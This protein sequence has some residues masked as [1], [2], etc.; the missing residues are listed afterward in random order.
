MKKVIMGMFVTVL[1]ITFLSAPA[2]AKLGLDSAE[3]GRV[4]IELI[5]WWPQVGGS[6][7]FVEDPEAIPTDAITDLDID[8]VLNLKLQDATLEVGVWLNLTKRNRFSLYWLMDQRSGTGLLDQTA[9]ISDSTFIEGTELSSDIDVQRIKF[10]YE[11]ALI[12][13][14]LGRLAV[15]L[16]ISYFDVLTKFDGEVDLVGTRETESERIQAPLPVLSLAAE[17]HLPLGFGVF[18]DGCGMAVNYKNISGRYFDVRGGVNW[19]MRY[20]FAQAG[21]Q[22]IYVYADAYDLQV[23]YGLRGPF[24]SLGAK[25]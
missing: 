5:A 4:G 7:N 19:K 25:F 1:L 16:G 10:L 17:I 9:Q 23:D 2:P 12:R 8:D 3:K 6:I 22:Y 14:D 13:R 21:Y 24:M 15:G 20:A 11:R 18:A